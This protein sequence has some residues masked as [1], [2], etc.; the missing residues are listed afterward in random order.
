[1]S[2][3]LAAR[4]DNDTSMGNTEPLYIRTCS[5]CHRDFTEF[6]NIDSDFCEDHQ[7]CVLC[8][9]CEV[10]LLRPVIIDADHYCRDCALD[11]LRDMIEEMAS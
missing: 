9:V 4:P 11:V 7:D 1:M 10:A 8:N 2:V 6:D 3:R 5:Y